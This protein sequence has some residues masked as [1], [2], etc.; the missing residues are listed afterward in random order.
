[1]DVKVNGSLDS[2][3]YWIVELKI[4]RVVNKTNS[5]VTVLDFRR[6]Y[7]GLFRDPLG[8]TGGK[9]PGGQWGQER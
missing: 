8:K 4:L 9:G 1:M 6:T 2:S 7:L 5:K 3:N